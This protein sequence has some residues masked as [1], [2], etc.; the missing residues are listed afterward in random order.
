M[1]QRPAPKLLLMPPPPQVAGIKKL[2]SAKSTNCP[3]ISTHQSS[4]RRGSIV[5]PGHELILPLL[6]IAWCKKQFP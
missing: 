2:Y 6:H 1:T 3:P 5:Y 4:F